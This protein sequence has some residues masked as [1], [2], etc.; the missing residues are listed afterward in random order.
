MPVVKGMSEELETMA[1][2]LTVKPIVGDEG[3]IKLSPRFPEQLRGRPFT[4]LIDDVP[5]ENLSEERLLK[6]GEH[7]L[8]VLSSDYRNE[9]RRFVVERAKVLDLII[10]LKDPTPL[11]I[12][13]APENARIFLDNAPVLREREP[14]P[15]EP[16]VHEA[17][18]QIGD[19]T[20][21]KSLTIERGKT[22]RVA[23]AVDINV[24]ESE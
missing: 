2:H 12:F 20:L 14:I 5:V 10:E 17:K 1:F 24:L 18:F 11:I 8:V 3:A 16:G 7:H 23:M 13:E 9:S 22:Y 21:I 15:V 4:V 19:Y 6:E